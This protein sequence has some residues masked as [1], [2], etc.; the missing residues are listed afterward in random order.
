MKSLFCILKILD[1]TKRGTKSEEQ[2]T[3][4]ENEKKQNKT[5]QNRKTKTERTKNAWVI[6]L[7]IGVGIKVG[8]F[9][10][11]HFSISL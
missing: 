8:F 4:R 10:I 2:A 11:F 7:L 5:K 6:R 9:P 3:E 1:V